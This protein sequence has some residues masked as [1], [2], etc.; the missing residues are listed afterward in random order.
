MNVQLVSV[1]ILSSAAK[2]KL[3]ITSFFFLDYSK[4][5]FKSLMDESWAERI[6]HVT[7]TQPEPSGA[8]PDHYKGLLYS[9]S[10]SHTAGAFVSISSY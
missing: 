1:V 6:L 3:H 7:D 2:G 9:V 4:S 10:M 8:S 5:G